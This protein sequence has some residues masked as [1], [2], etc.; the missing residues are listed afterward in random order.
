M[1]KRITSLALVFVMVLSMLAAE[2]PA[3][4]ASAAS[5]QL[6]VTADKTEANPGD[7]IN[8]TITLGPVSDLGTMQ[9]RL[10]IPTG[11]T[12]VPNSGKLADNLMN[13]LGFDDVSFTEKSKII[14]GVASA[15]DYKSDT[16]TVLATFRCKV[17]EGFT[18]T[19][20]VDLTYLE[21]YSC[22]TWEEHTSEYMVVPA[23]VN[24]TKP[25]PTKHTQLRVTADKTAAKPGDTINFT[26]TLGPVSNMGTM[27]MDVVIP[28]GLTY[29]A[30]SGKLADSLTRTLGFDKANWVEDKKRIDGISSA[31][32]YNSDTDTVLATF[33]CTVNEGF[34]GTTEV[35]LG[36]LEFYSCR[37]W[38]DNTSY[39]SVVKAKVK[40]AAPNTPDGDED[41]DASIAEQ[42]AAVKAVKP[43]LRSQLVK[44]SAGKKAI[45]ITWTN[46][47]EVKLDGVE[48]FRSLKKNSGYGKKPIYIS[49]TDKYTNTAVRKGKTYYYKARGFVTIGGEKIYTDWSTKALRTVK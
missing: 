2:A 18:G 13:T 27:Q 47:G 35:G 33:Q 4:A 26:V 25:V 1:T 34:T 20:K 48:I 28:T 29:V 21:F 16:D 12:Y 36:N 10:V 49:K 5:T 6:K 45:R 23:T 22:R 17:D 30:N 24:V 44:T 37:T 14:G 42:K 31:S 8:F 11:L 9:M 43:K 19:A 39:Y 46:L 15:A 32:D 3:F 40:V 7:I 41:G 38:E